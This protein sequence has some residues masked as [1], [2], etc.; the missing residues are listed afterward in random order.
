MIC[1]DPMHRY[2]AMEAYHD[3]AL[4]SPKSSLVDTPTFVREAVYV[5]DPDLEEAYVQVLDSRS[6]KLKNIKSDVA[7]K[8]KPSDRDRVP[9]PLGETIKQET[10][11]AATR[12]LRPAK[13][14]TGLSDAAKKV[15]KQKKAP[16]KDR[17]HDPTR[18]SE[19]RGS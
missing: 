12:Q 14:V 17:R 5:P 10:V 9:T 11:V 2:K 3:P 18:K 1:P 8:R 16:R 4:H 15:V 19:E 6:R 7:D 13:T